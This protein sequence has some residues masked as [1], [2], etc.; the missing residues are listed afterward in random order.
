MNLIHIYHSIFEVIDEKL[1]KIEKNDMN[2][3]NIIQSAIIIVGIAI[4]YLP[5]FLIFNIIISI[6]Y[7][8][9]ITRVS[10]IGDDLTLERYLLRRHFTRSLSYMKIGRTNVR[11]L[12]KLIYGN[13]K[14]SEVIINDYIREFCLSSDDFVGRYRIYN[15]EILSYLTRNI[16]IDKNVIIKSNIND[17]RTDYTRIQFIRRDFA[18]YNKSTKLIR[19]MITEKW[20]R[21]ICG[22]ERI[23]YLDAR[24]KYENETHEIDI[25]LKIYIVKSMIENDECVELDSL[26]IL[27]RR[28]DQNFK[29]QIMKYYH[30]KLSPKFDK[31]LLSIV[32]DYAM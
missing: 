10:D 25:T 30:D 8:F 4:F 9:I 6:L 2:D 7:P 22:Q 32:I 24:K 27:Y 15:P 3:M 26:K 20:R 31:N 5:F 13:L 21:I 28:I 18:L 17:I 14:D 1:E 11:I 23:R 19:N 16:N 29:N 12:N